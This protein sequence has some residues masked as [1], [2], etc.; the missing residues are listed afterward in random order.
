MKTRQ[1]SDQQG[2]GCRSQLRSGKGKSRAL[3][4]ALKGSTDVDF[5]LWLPEPCRKHFHATQPPT[6]Q[7]LVRTAQGN[8]CKE[9]VKGAEQVRSSTP[10][11]FTSKEKRPYK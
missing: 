8:K 9:R 4:E 3:P 5:G 1:R 11:S 10:P 2:A 6:W 7:C